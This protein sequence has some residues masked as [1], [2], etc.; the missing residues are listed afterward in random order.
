MTNDPMTPNQFQADLDRLGPDLDRWP[1]VAAARALLAGSAEAAGQWAEANRV[2]TA[3]RAP[4]PDVSALKARILAAAQTLALAQASGQAI[5]ANVVPFPMRRV[6]APAALALAA[7]LI[8]GVFAG[9]TGMIADPL[10]NGANG[11]DT[12][13]EFQALLAGENYDS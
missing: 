7:S 1:H 11:D 9:W 2:D 13:Y 12:T 5:R 4:V 6:V 10:G 8:F 3:L